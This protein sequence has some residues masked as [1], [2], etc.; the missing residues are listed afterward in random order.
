MNRSR[1]R[2]R[3]LVV[4]VLLSLS[5]VALGLDVLTTAWTKSNL[6]SLNLLTPN[7]LT[8]ELANNPKYLEEDSIRNAPY[9]AE[10]LEFQWID[11]NHDGNEE[12]LIVFPPNGSSGV[13]SLAV[14]SKRPS[15]EIRVGLL[16]F[17]AEN[18]V[19][20]SEATR[21]HSIVVEQG[22]ANPTHD[23]VWPNCIQ[24]LNGDRKYE[25]VVMNSVLSIGPAG[26]A[27]VAQ[28]IYC[29]NP[30]TG[31]LDNCS[32]D[33]RNYFEKK[34]IPAINAKIKEAGTEPEDYRV[35]VE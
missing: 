32:R 30:K 13:R 24:D 23:A 22:Y 35:S 34:V 33:F 1:N 5:G 31:D 26:A 21:L 25:I 18:L 16:P 29:F 9:L 12:L 8:T 17:G 15:G 20:G 6:D 27:S 19:V 11:L 10:K 2:V 28:K 3:L 14:F 4:A 7:E